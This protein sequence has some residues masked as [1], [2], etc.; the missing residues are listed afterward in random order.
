MDLNILFL[1]M[2]AYFAAVEQQLRP[3]LRGKPVA[4]VPVEADTT[5]C[6]AAS[7]EAKPYGIKTGTVVR[8]AKR[9]CPSLVL[10]PA[11]PEL[12]VRMHHRIVKAINTCLPVDKVHS[13]DEMSC[14]LIGSE[15]RT[16]RAAELAGLIKRTLRREVGDHLR[17]SI[18]IAPNRFLAKVAADMQKPDGLTVLTRAE[19]P[20]KLHSLHLT[21]LPGIGPRM[22]ERLHRS[23]I[24]TVAQLCRSPEDCLA[25]VWR[26]VTGRVWWHHLRGYDLPEPPTVRRTVGHSH[27]L[28]PKDRDAPSAHAVLS[29][30]LHKAAA[31][32]R[33]LGCHAGRLHVHVGFFGKPTWEEHRSLGLCR[34]TLTML[35][36]F[37][38]MWP[39][40][41]PGRPLRVG[42]TLSDLSADGDVPVPLFPSERRRAGLAGAMDRLNDKFGAHAVYFGGMHGALDS[43]PMRIAFTS[44]PDPDLPI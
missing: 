33:R 18:G 30:L 38:E 4:V 22:F 2:N 14:R 10:V 20:H 34:D 17:C 26:G 19:L 11:R 40:R 13:I 8:E 37:D 24:D 29:R 9:L 41:P 5:C 31:R 6:I 15:R 32:L 25:H 21:D 42:V 16:E 36:A 43:A 28:P 1:D 7:Y 35:E 39:R 44:I 12:Y 23:G 3:E 27:V